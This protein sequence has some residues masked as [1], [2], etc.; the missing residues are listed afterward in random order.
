MISCDLSS[1][2]A[3]PMCTLA[4]G[5]PVVDW[6]GLLLHVVRTL[7]QQ[8]SG[9]FKLSGAT[10]FLRDGNFLGL[11]FHYCAASLRPPP[12]RV[13]S[14]RVVEEP[15]ITAPA[16]SWPHWWFLLTSPAGEA[17]GSHGHFA[18]P[19][20][21]MCGWNQQR[22]EQSPSNLDNAHVSLGVLITALHLAAPCNPHLGVSTLSPLLKTANG[23]S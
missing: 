12:H 13:F 1:L 7:R 9:L 3:Q 19:R 18:C 10:H 22:A 5:T 16:S 15:C 8:P 6:S 21:L 20:S 4:A 17:G 2:T 11:P 14:T 23:Y